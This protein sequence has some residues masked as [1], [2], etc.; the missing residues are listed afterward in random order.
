[1]MEKFRKIAAPSLRRRGLLASQRAAV[2][3]L[4]L[5]LLSVSMGVAVGGDWK[6]EVRRLAG[7]E[8]IVLA[9]DER[10]EVLV[11]VRSKTS[12]IPAS[13][14]K[15]PTS[16]LAA[17]YLGMEHR[18]STEF[19]VQDGLLVVR[20]Q[21]DPMLVSEEIDAV[22]A[23]LV[24]LLPDGKLA[25]VGIDDSYFEEGIK[26]PGVGASDNPYDALNS[27]TAVNFNTINV[28]V[29]GKDVRSAESQTPI[30]PLA[31]EIALRR[32]V[33]GKVRVNLSSS[34]DDVRRYAGELIAAKMRAAGALVG[35][36][37]ERVHVGDGKPLYVH[38]SSKTVADACAGLLHYSNNYIAN[39]V[40]LAVGAAHSGAPASLKKSVAAANEFISEHKELA[41]LLMTEG[42]GISYE[43]RTTAQAMIA[44]LGLFI[45]H[46]KLLRV[47]Q[48]SDSKTG[49]L[50]VTR[51]V[52]GYID[53][54]DHGT[55]RYVISLDASGSWR[56]WKIVEAMQK[57]L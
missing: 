26:I 11:D 57:A 22:A 15:I 29:H 40:F 54:K 42:S 14:L 48:D 16:L 51:S 10:G 21:G 27:A 55:V 3:V 49:T 32:G 24:P 30:T 39:Q 6:S 34:A 7:K 50:S 17:H 28:V 53:T 13:I 8:G 37:V 31:R 25:G 23:A 52:A 45:P 1:M 20:G 41:G 47:R 56:R 46:R 12:F 33:Q 4:V 18:F 36:R 43:N 2:S 38:K 5:G 9:V 35:E 44:A 19:F